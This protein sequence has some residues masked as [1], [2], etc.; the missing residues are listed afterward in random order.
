[1]ATKFFENCPRCKHQTMPNDKVVAI[2]DTY[3]TIPVRMWRYDCPE[4]LWTW[5]NL[6]QRKHNEQEYY[7]ARKRA[8]QNTG[9]GYNG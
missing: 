1:M 4:C 7:K 6:A 8:Q 3:G 2:D 5:S 9:W